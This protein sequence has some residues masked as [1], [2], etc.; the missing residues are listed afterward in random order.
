LREKHASK[1]N[2]LLE[3]LKVGSKEEE[4]DIEG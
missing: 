4:Q 3:E 2:V 1:L